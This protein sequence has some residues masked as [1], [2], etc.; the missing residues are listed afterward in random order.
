MGWLR[1]VHRWVGLALAAVVVAVAAS[2]GL[3]L[4]RE[5]YYRAAYPSL[6]APITAAQLEA[7]ADVIT[8][9]ETR[10]Q[11]EGIRLIKFPR[12]GMNVFQVW[13]GDGTE[14]FVDPHG[15]AVLDRWRWYERL[16]AFLFELH[17]HLVSERPGTVANGIVALG[18]VFM[19]LTGLVFWWPARRTAFRLRG[20]LPRRI[21]PAALLRSHAAVGALAALPI[22]LFAGTGAAI[23]FYDEVGAVMS[24]LFDRRPPEQPDARVT[25]ALR[26]A[27]E[28][29]AILARL[30]TTFPDGR[31][32]FYYPGTPGNARLMF[33]KQLPG[34]WHPNG[35]SYVVIDPYTANVLQAIDARAQGAGTRFMQAIYPVHAA[36]AGGAA[37]IA[38][39]ACAALALTWLAAGG[40][41]SYLSR[42]SAGRVRSR[43]AAVPA[44]AAVPA[45]AAWS[46]AIRLTELPAGVVARLH[47]TELDA[48]S[49]AQLRALGLTDASLL[50]VCKQGEPCVVQVRTTRLGLSSRIARHVCVLA[51]AA[52]SMPWR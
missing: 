35:R 18:L 47:E 15:G 51:S 34:E 32:V 4:L 12:A 1:I 50:R 24:K 23:V 52:G 31:T 3:L 7:R 37:M 9:I 43:I 19:A 20:A 48:E 2:G 11:H 5:P 45:G 26:P 39:A 40:V 25:P 22:V 44:S 29:S 42:R 17:A 36:K 41:W 49:R 30:D 21:S 8:A 10:W 14:A 6:R 28:W 38:L 16:P 46:G 27:Q 13:L 33:R